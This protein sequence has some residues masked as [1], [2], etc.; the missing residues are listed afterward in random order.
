MALQTIGKMTLKNGGG[1]VVQLGFTYR[2]ENGEK[3]FSRRTGDI[4]LGFAGTADPGNFDVPDDTDVSLYAMVVAGNNNEA[5]RAFH[6]KRG[7]S[8]VAH[9]VITG[10]TINNDLGLTGVSDH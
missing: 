2:D 5:T 10:T 8:N 6:Y 1:F 7:D 4:T 9:Y 3:Q